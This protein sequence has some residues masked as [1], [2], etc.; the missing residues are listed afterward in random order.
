MSSA[1]PIFYED[2]LQIH[3]FGPFE[4][5]VNGE[6]LE[7]RTPKDLKVLAYLVLNHDTPIDRSTL[8]RTFWGP[9]NDG[10]PVE[11]GDASHLLSRTLSVLV[12]AL[13]ND[14]WRLSKPTPQ[15]HQFNTAG[16]TID[17]QLQEWKSGLTGNIDAL[18]NCAR[19]Y[20][21]SVFL[22]GWTDAWVLDARKTLRSAL[23]H[24]L[25]AGALRLREHHRWDEAVR[26][27]RLIFDINPFYVYLAPTEPGT[28][29]AR[30]SSVQFW[31]ELLYE[32]HRFSEMGK[33][34][35]AYLEQC[36][37]HKRAVNSE[38]RTTYRT[39]RDQADRFLLSENSGYLPSPMTEFI[40]RL[41]D[42]DAISAILTRSRLTTLCGT[43][44]VGKTRLAI[45]VAVEMRDHFYDR[46]WFIDLSDLP[47]FSDVQ[48]IAAQISQSIRLLRQPNQPLAD[49]ICEALRT[50]EVLL[51]LDNCEH[52]LDGSAQLVRRILESCHHVTI[53]ATSRE[54]LEIDGEA[55]WQVPS[56]DYPTSPA[57][58]S[59]E[60]LLQFRALRLLA[61]RAGSVQRPFVLDAENAEAAAHICKQ[62]HGIPLAIEL[63]AVQIQRKF[64][65]AAEVAESLQNSLST[66]VDG[67]RAAPTRQRTIAGAINWSYR[68]L[69]P[70]EQ[71]AFDRLSIFSGGFTVEAAVNVC[72]YAPLTSVQV[73][74]AVTTL[75]DKSLIER[76]LSPLGDRYH[77]L[78]TIREFVQFNL[79][80]ASGTNTDTS[81]V[82]PA[83]QPGT[84]LTLLHQEHLR[85]YRDFAIESRRGF[86][87]GDQAIMLDLQDA[88]HENVRSA[89][90]WALADGDADDIDIGTRLA[91]SLGWYWHSR[92]YYTEATIFLEKY[93]NICPKPPT[94]ERLDLLQ[95][96]GNIAYAR[97]DYHK[98]HQCFEQ[99]LEIRTQIG[100]GDSV[101]VGRASLAS[102]LAGLD[103][104]AKAL[105]LYDENR[106]VF[107]KTGDQKNLSITLL[108]MGKSYFL[109][110]DY[111]EAEAQYT[112]SM[113]ILRQRQDTTNLGLVA[114]NLGETKYQLGKF[115]EALPL[116]K[117]ALVLSR[118]TG[119]RTRTV[120][121][122]IN[123]VSLAVALLKY[124]MAAKIIG[125]IETFSTNTDHMPV[126]QK[127]AGHRVVVASVRDHLGDVAYDNQVVRGARMSEEGVVALISDLLSSKWEDLPPACRFA[128]TGVNEATPVTHHAV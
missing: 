9:T 85:H 102:A 86:I 6:P 12:R 96:L 91:G 106:S 46:A 3:V 56:L 10:S 128:G 31:L 77:L 113:T 70:L 100:D 36:E 83:A 52:L 44:G 82:T 120:L 57:R 48:A 30:Q 81:T 109:L 27:L 61:D 26:C 35:D 24:A 8:L 32:R 124:E 67:S 92:G 116:F 47:E 60:E 110:G 54:P 25:M 1:N 39:L 126:P 18:E 89:L 51:I 74:N 63:A 66:L 123:C 98:A 75:A 19:R 80:T 64:R 41:D 34:H 76:R 17:F 88:E 108:N 118:Q 14:S 68:L 93:L 69:S 101:G 55:V 28:T 58:Y 112:L 4:A 90:E 59:P 7:L 42:I 87:N 117:E 37:R 40:P 73:S 97:G 16:D 45:A 107:S 33:V 38:V 79:Q 22:Q 105:K 95:A 122:L 104:H 121:S 11:P 20:R 125:Y 111:V 5:L 65:S 23:L 94:Q 50:K 71:I 21:G 103:Y 72:G 127:L 99:G 115:A 2:R 15:S 84:S 114:N 78:N 13:K 43:G 53:L 29:S 49:Q 62:L 119:N